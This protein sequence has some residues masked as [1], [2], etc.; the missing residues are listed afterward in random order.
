MLTSTALRKIDNYRRA[1]F[2]LS[3]HIREEH[4]RCLAEMQDG[5]GEEAFSSAWKAGKALTLEQALREA[6][7]N[8][9][10]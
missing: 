3:L 4:D 10:A 9:E 6:F 7:D 1:S 5:L 2:F 8:L